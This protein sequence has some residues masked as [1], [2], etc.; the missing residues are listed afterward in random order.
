[1]D[2]QV[3]YWCNKTSQA[4]TQY[5]VSE[6]QMQGDHMTLS[7][8]LLKGIGDLPEEKLT[9]TAM[10]GPNVNWKVLEITKIKQEEDEYPPLE[11]I[12]SCCLHVINGALHSAVLVADWPIEVLWGMHKLLKD[13]PARRA[14]YMR[15]SVTGLY[16]EKFCVILWVENKLVAD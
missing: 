3:W 16:P 13:A 14:E 8:N 10:G 2:L 11:D 4:V 9:H 1:M 15:V 7:E 12:R 6:F 5:Y